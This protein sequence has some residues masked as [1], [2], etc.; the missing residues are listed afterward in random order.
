MTILLKE[1][2]YI[3]QNLI[4]LKR[5]IKQSVLVFTQDVLVS[6]FPLAVYI[7][8]FAAVTTW[9]LTDPL[10]FTEESTFCLLS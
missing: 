9:A 7:F 4:R 6:G 2:E 10:E 1:V 3:I 8:T 5:Q